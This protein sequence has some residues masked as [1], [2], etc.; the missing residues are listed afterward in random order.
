MFSRATYSVLTNSNLPQSEQFLI[1]ANYV[2]F[3][4]DSLHSR[5]SSHGTFSLAFCEVLT[6]FSVGIDALVRIK[7]YFVRI[8]LL[9]SDFH[10]TFILAISC[11]AL[12][13]MWT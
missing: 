10:L 7:R 11:S 4:L 6:T 9:I 2:E 13:F 1:L 12:C 5:C 8:S 3:L